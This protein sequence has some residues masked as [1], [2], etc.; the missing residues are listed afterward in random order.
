MAALQKIISAALPQQGNV[1]V[2][3]VVSVSPLCRLQP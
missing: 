2:M 1:A 3:L